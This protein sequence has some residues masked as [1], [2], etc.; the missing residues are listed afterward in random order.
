MY[1]VT[2]VHSIY[3]TDSLYVQIITRM[4]VSFVSRVCIVS[5][6]QY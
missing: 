3:L 4:E 1:S 6:C 2:V 5:K